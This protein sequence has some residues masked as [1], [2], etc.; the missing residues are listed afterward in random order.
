MTPKTGLTRFNQDRSGP[1]TENCIR[2]FRLF[3]S[4]ATEI[5][6]LTTALCKK[7]FFRTKKIGP[8]WGPIAVC[9]WV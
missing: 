7:Q 6:L 9:S 3:F 2:W 8:L 5:K 4:F 1:A